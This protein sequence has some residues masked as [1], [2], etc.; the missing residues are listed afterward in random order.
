MYVCLCIYAEN[1]SKRLSRWHPLHRIN[2]DIDLTSNTT[3]ERATV[4]MD[5]IVS[6]EV[7][8]L[9]T[10]ISTSFPRAR[11]RFESSVC[12]KMYRQV[13]FLTTPEVACGETRDLNQSPREKSNFNW[14]MC[15]DTYILGA[16]IDTVWCWYGSIH[17]FSHYIAVS[18]DTCIPT[19]IGINEWMYICV[20]VFEREK[21][22][23]SEWVSERERE[24]FFFFSGF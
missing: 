22:R 21:E 11:E 4:G 8:L 23:G 10:T 3:D 1:P 24:R 6:L 18:N 17:A 5:S 12:P 14:C 7:P 19:H 15:E 2:V 13:T 20:Y 9:I 16:Y